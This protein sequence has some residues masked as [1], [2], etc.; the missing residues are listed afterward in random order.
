MQLRERYLPSAIPI[1]L[2]DI[3]TEV[4]GFMLALGVDH[5][6][7]KRSTDVS[8]PGKPCSTVIMQMGE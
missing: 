1:I 3:R 2:P 6:V 8:A 5:H 4:V 7:A